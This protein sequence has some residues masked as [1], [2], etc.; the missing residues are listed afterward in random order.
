MPDSN[1]KVLWGFTMC[2]DP[3]MQRI[4]LKRGYIITGFGSNLKDMG[5]QH[6]NIALP[7]P[8]PSD[9]NNVSLHMA[10]N[11]KTGDIIAVP[12][13]VCNDLEKKFVSFSLFE[14]LSPATGINVGLINHDFHDTP[15]DLVIKI[16]PFEAEFDI[17]QQECS[18]E[19]F[20]SL[21]NTLWRA[22]TVHDNVYDRVILKFEQWLHGL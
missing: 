22:G 19:D 3:V 12:E 5:P 8:D 6:K 13:C 2:A 21:K 1:D 4:F 7:D 18:N 16:K 15:L 11:V 9:L 14:V 17:Q 20:P 10:L